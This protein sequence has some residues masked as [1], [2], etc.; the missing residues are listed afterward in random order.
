MSE[1]NKSAVM[2]IPEAPF[3][4]DL[5]KY[6][7]ERGSAEDV[8]RGMDEMYQKYK[9]ME[10]NIVQRRNNLKKKIPEIQ[11]ALDA[12]M[13][14]RKL[15][16]AGK[17]TADVNFQLTSNCWSQAEVKPSESVCLWL[18]ANVMLE[19]TQEEAQS[20]LERN[21]ATAEEKLEEVENEMG[22]LKE[23]IT[24]MEVNMARVYNWDVRKRREAA[25]A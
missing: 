22:Y 11:G 13:Q 7:A 14:L 15:N 5:D 4:D 8:L 9:F 12:I 23:Q 17:D 3:P 6:M 19:Y 20:L 18:G 1:E 10:I 21:K 2:G 16:E 25:S 24:T